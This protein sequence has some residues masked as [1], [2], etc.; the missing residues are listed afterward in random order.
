MADVVEID[1]K[2]GAIITRDF[3]PE[4]AAQ[5]EADQL[6]H[7]IRQAAEAVLTG[8]KTTITDRAV[9][10]LDN[11]RAFIDTPNGDLT[12]AD[13]VGQVKDLARQNNALIRLVLNLLD[14]VD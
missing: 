9:A 14:G 11:N 8:N 10:A 6:E 12:N 4:E 1:A 2:T 7:G 3:T 13:V 5:R